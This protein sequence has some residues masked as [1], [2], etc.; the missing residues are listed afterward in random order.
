MHLYIE[1]KHPESNF[2]S[3]FCGRI[4]PESN[5]TL[6]SLLAGVRNYGNRHVVLY[7]PRGI[8]ED[9]GYHSRKDDLKYISETEL[10]G[11]VKPEV[12]KEW[13][14]QRLSVY[15]NNQAGIPTW[16]THPVWHSHSWLNCDEYEQ[17]LSTYKEKPDACLNIEYDVILVC[18]KKFEAMGYKSRIVFWFDN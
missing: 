2:W 7:P 4:N 3:S 10:K 6:F 11:S 1:Y 16:V 14:D 13:V 9:C 17:V 12:A 18:M 15:V 8:P 5:Y